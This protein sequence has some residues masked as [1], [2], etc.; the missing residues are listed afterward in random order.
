MVEVATSL[1]TARAK[2]KSLGGIL[3]VSPEYEDCRRIAAERGLPLQEV[4]RIVELETRRFLET[5]P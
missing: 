1:G 3:S 2:I 5:Q 4:A